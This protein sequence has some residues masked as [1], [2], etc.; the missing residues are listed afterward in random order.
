MT[1]EKIGFT[2]GTYDGSPML[3]RTGK[4]DAWQ[5]FFE[6][7]GIDGNYEIEDLLK[8]RLSDED[9]KILIFDSESSW[10]V[11]VIRDRFMAQEICDKAN[12][13]LKEVLAESILG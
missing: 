5:A 1:K 11:V 4:S 6:L 9:K 8:Q 10:F 3:D 2:L 13:I 7:T 12:R